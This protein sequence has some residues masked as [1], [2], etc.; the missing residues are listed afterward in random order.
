MRLSSIS[1]VYR[2]AFA[3]GVPIVGLLVFAFLFAQQHRADAERM[4]R[5]ADLTQ[6]GRNL[7]AVVHELQRERGNTAG[8]IGSGQGPT[9]TSRLNSQRS[10][11]DVVIEQYFTALEAHDVSR[12]SEAYAT[13]I[14]TVSAQLRA[15]PEHRAQVDTGTLD[16]GGG[17]APYTGTI[18]AVLSA[19][20]EEIHESDDAGLTEGMISLLNLM[21]AKENAG[22]ERAIGS[23][24]LGNGAVNRRN[25][26]RLFELQ[27]AQIAF[28]HEF[29]SVMGTQ[30]A[31]RFRSTIAPTQADVDAYRQ[32]L[33]DGGY[34][35]PVPQG[36]GG[37]WFDA[38]TRRI[39]A[40]M[41]VETQFAS[42]LEAEAEAKLASS[43]QTAWIVAALAFVI[44]AG[45]I[46]FSTAITMG[47]VQPIK[48]ITA[49][50]DSITRGEEDVQI[51]GQHR[52]DEIGVL[53][54]AARSFLED[55]TKRR[56]LERQKLEQDR[57]TF[58]DRAAMMK[59]M[60]SEV[61]TASERSLGRVVE[62]ASNIRERSIRV[63]DALESAVSQAQRVADQ[64]NTSQNQSVEAADQ[65]NELIYAIN[66][67]TEQIARSDELAR[68]AVAKAEA[69][70]R[71]VGELRDAAAQIGN[72]IE[73]INGIAEQTNLL[74]LNATIEAARAGEAGKGFAVVAAEVKALA[75]QTNKSAS[76]ISDRV[77]GIQERTG[78]T[79]DS[80]DAI[81]SAIETL[82]EVTTAVSAAMEEQ[83]ASTAGFR[84]FVEQ[85]QNATKLVATGV[86]E[87]ADVASS[88]SSEAGAFADTADEMSDMSELARFEI[89]SIVTTAACRADEEAG[90]AADEANAA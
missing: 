30:W 76:E 43:R 13:R 65:A 51:H 50:L 26:E 90:F 86:S 21:Q 6:F 53:A 25:H 57:K 62:S 84:A 75:A 35:N 74:A 8:Y 1:V 14:E 42:Y 58:E 48:R 27:S 11:T 23:N 12:Y 66:E 79:V 7:S 33:A 24:S 82:S 89:P 60:S 46:W 52:Q 5:I 22:I 67:V 88:M 17:V 59:Q 47:V 71:T 87:I 61:E 85:T 9:F 49:N 3:V 68:D 69:S 4:S 31:E 78:E 28:I 36:R 70:G 15:L 64:A 20:V 56:S 10:R 16:L 73:I 77:S 44:T 45:T 55:A 54:R 72:F 39:D 80:I 29:E 40:M 81:S 38:S 18:N 32:L 37:D 41:D 2:L 63:R 19:F 34:G 83:R